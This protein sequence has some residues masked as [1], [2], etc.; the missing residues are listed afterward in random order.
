MKF[1]SMFHSNDTMC[2]RDE[3]PIFVQGKVTFDG[4]LIKPAYFVLS[5]SPTYFERFS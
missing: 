4:K 5:L 3:S 1:G 2:R